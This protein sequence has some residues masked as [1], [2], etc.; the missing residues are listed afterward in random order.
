MIE[1]KVNTHFTNLIADEILAN[2]YFSTQSLAE[3]NYEKLNELKNNVIYSN[4]KYQIVSSLLS[5][6][7]FFNIQSLISRISLMLERER[8]SNFG[9]KNQ[10]E[11][12]ESNLAYLILSGKI[13]STEELGFSTEYITEL[14]NVKKKELENS[15]VKYDYDERTGKTSQISNNKAIILPYTPSAVIKKIAQQ[16]P[17]YKRV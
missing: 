10:L 15:F 6:A 13:K 7:M 1:T 2:Y 11:I 14:L 17:G 4:K 5:V 9:Y 16:T 8:K 3:Y 12:F